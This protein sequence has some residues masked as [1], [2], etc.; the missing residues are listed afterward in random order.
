[1]KRATTPT[2]RFTLPVDASLIRRFLLTYTQNGKVVLEKRETDMAVEGNEW[3][4]K[5][6]QEEANL[7]DSSSLA[8]AQIRILTTGGDAMASQEYA[9]YVGRVLN[10][11]VLA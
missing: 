1:M 5:L 9:I 3:R 10:D 6:T 8:H 11:E 4:I 2:H 7:F